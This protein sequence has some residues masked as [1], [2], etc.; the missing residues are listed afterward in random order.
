MQTSALQSGAIDIGFTRPVEPAHAAFLHSECFETEPLYAV[1]PKNHSLAKQRSIY[2]RELTVERFILN[3]RKYSPA[4]FDK[5]ISLCAEAGF[6][7]TIV[8]T[9]TVLSGVIALVEAGEGI[10]ILPHGSK[11]F[12][13]DALMFIPIADPSASIDIVVAWSPQHE[14]P[15]LRPFLELVRSKRKKQTAMSREE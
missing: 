3:D 14:T 9:A 11:I 12:R 13:N 4:L 5:I 15:V 8:T 6:S 7:P 2:M 10:A 1:L